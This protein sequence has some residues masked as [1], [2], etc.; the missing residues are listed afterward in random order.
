ML[1]SIEMKDF[2]S[3][4][5]VILHTD[6]ALYDAV[7]LML[8]NKITGATVLDEEGHVVGVV[9]EM[10]LLR[11]LEQIAYYNEG[12]GEVGDYMTKEIT[13]IDEK[14]NIF[15]IANKL[16]ELKIRRL[17]VVENGIF[18]GKISCRSILQ[19]MKDSMCPHD[20][21]EDDIHE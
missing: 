17:P 14:M 13:V 19:A 9:S 5:P 15:D 20:D 8:E 2:M 10:D 11:A 1:Q 18:V 6:T 16:L 12:D 21:S 4:D 7:H 3:K